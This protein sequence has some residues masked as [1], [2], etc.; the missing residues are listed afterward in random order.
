MTGRGGL[1]RSRAAGATPIELFFDLVYVFAVTQLSHHLLEHLNLRGALETLMLLLVVW[2]AWMYTTWATSRFDPD[3]APVRLMLLAT[4]LVSLVMSASIPGAFAAQALL[5]A[6]T[7]VFI[8]LGRTAFLLVALGRGHDNAPNFLRIF[9]WFVITAVF[10][11]AGAL[12]GGTVQFVLWGVAIVLDYTAPLHGYRTPGLGRSLTSEWIIEG[13]HLAERCQ[14][15]VIVALGESILVTGATAAQL[16]VSVEN[17]AAFVVAFVG[18]AAMWWIYFDRT[19]EA[20]SEAI[21]AA[22]DPGRFARSAYNYF[23]V[24]MVAGIILTAVGDEL[25]ISHPDG[26][27]GLGAIATVLGGP[28][29]YLLGNGLFNAALTRRVPWARLVA[30]GVLAVLALLAQFM[31]LLALAVAAATVVVGV[32]IWDAVEGRRVTKLTA[33]D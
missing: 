9:A 22:A 20:G 16:P 12:L 11:I 28:V 21:A 17:T 18:S 30:I 27:A 23:H 24:V 2:W 15:F 26:H 5:F 14:L 29:V 4:M 10:W 6:G 13:G 1:L 25:S 31:T 3:R 7:Y 8:Q 19:A 32:G 33:S